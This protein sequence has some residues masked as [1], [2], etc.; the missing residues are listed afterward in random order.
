MSTASHVERGESI[1]ARIAAFS[2]DVV[3]GLSAL[4]PS[5]FRVTRGFCGV[6]REFH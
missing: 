6:F 1:Q 4:M 2:A 5:E 3:Y